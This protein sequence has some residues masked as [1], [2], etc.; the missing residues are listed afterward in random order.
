MNMRERIKQEHGNLKK[1]LMLTVATMLVCL[2]ILGDNYKKTHYAEGTHINQVNCSTFTK[3]EAKE[4]IEQSEV[5][6]S[7]ADGTCFSQRSIDIGRT[8]NDMTEL[9]G[10]LRTQNEKNGGDL[11]DF[12]LTS[13]S[14]YVDTA[15]LE[16]RLERFFSECEIPTDT[17]PQNAYLRLTEEG[18]IEIVPEVRGNY[19]DIAE[20]LSFACDSLEKGENFI[21]FTPITEVEPEVRTNNSELALKADELNK[22]LNVEIEY[23]LTD[24]STYSLN[25]EVTQYWI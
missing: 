22:V 13:E 15:I 12:A 14:F 16:E 3:E 19:I 7:F 6:I 9:E 4:K 5:I 25:H 20:A 10:F 17:K 18:Y 1:F 11:K 2:V 21:D 8:I 24:G 23:T